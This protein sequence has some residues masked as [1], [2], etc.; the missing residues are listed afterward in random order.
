MIRHPAI[1]PHCSHDSPNKSPQ[2]SPYDYHTHAHA[3]ANIG[4]GTYYATGRRNHWVLGVYFS[5]LTGEYHTFLPCISGLLTGQ[6]STADTHT[7]T[8]TQSKHKP[9]ADIGW[10]TLENK[11]NY[12]NCCDTKPHAQNS[13]QLQR[14]N[15]WSV[16]LYWGH[17]LLSTLFKAK[18]VR[19]GQHSWLVSNGSSS[20][21]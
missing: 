1:V 12:E 19:K 15:D 20:S 9:D 4:P 21:D 17:L 14:V 7:H 11:L 16:V 10:I 3:H 2:F 13:L 8:S 5:L 6:R 18:Y